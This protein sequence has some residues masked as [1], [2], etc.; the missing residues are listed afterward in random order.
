M[1]S[2]PHL[3]SYHISI[4]IYLYIFHKSIIVY[5]HTGCRTC[6]DSKY[7]IVKYKYYTFHIDTH[8]YNINGSGR[9]IYK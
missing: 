1:Y 8:I 7:N 5:E 3:V 2:A 4:S 6:Q 9:H